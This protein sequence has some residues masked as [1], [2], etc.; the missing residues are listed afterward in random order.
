MFLGFD[1]D[2]DYLESTARKSIKD[3]QLNNGYL[4]IEVSAA[5]AVT[6][7]VL[8]SAS[9]FIQ[10]HAILN[11]P[12]LQKEDF[13]SLTPF[14]P[15]VYCILQPTEVNAA[16]PGTLRKQPVNVTSERF[17]YFYEET[18]EA[19]ILQLKLGEEVFQLDLQVYWSLHYLL[20]KFNTL[21]AS[22]LCL[23]VWNQNNGFGLADDLVAKGS[24]ALNKDHLE[25]HKRALFPLDNGMSRA[26]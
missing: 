16:T 17:H 4:V 21:W 12:D 15:Y 22:F 14:E 9:T 3:D 7:L 25:L 24:V 26:E 2:T 8:Y 1:P 20:S 23:Q 6:R 10:V 11:V 18:D 5:C 19:A 13:I